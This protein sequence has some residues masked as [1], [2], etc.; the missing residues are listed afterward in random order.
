MDTEPPKEV[1]ERELAELLK[2]H[3]KA[4]NLLKKMLCLSLV[5]VIFL[6]PIIIFDIIHHKNCWAIFAFAS[7]VLNGNNFKKAWDLL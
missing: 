5:G 2:V 3:R 1:I 6:I 4:K 7:L